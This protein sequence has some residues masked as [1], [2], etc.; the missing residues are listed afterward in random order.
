MTRN[1][2][3]QS[4]SPYLLQHKDNPVHWWP[5]VPDA[6][7]TAKREG[8]PILLSIGYAAC[9]WCHVMAHES[10]ESEDIAALMNEHFINIK[11]DREERPDIDHIYMSALHAL[12]EHGGW[13]LTMF[14]TPDAKPFWGGTYFPPT[15]RYG[16]PGFPR[17][18]RE[19]ARIFHDVPDK[20]A[21]NA[22]AILGHLEQVAQGRETAGARELPDLRLVADVVG[23]LASVVDPI[24]GGIQGAPKFP[25]FSFFWLLWTGAMRLGDATARQAVLT[26]LT[27]I[28]QGG[29]YDHLAGGFAR[30]SV[31]ERWLVPHFEKMLYD[32]ALLVS[33]MTEVW[34]ETKDPLLEVRVRETVGW[35]LEDMR[36]PG[37]AFASSYDADSEGE[38]GKYYVWQRAEIMEILGADD[39][40]LFCE[41]Y[42]V[43]AGGNFE[44][45]NILNRLMQPELGDAADEQHLAALRARLLARRRERVAPGFDDKVLADWNGYAIAALARAG[46]AFEEPTWVQAAEAAFAFIRRELGNVDGPLLGHSWREGRCTTSGVASDYA[47]MIEAAIALHE[48]T[49]A[50]EPLAH[51]RAWV[52][53]LE[54]RFKHEAGG[55]AQS[56]REAADLIVRMRSA[57]DDATPNANAIMVGA[58]VRLFSMT[59]EP[60]YLERARSVAEAFVGELWVNVSAHTGLLAAL[61]EL[62]QP[63]HIVVVG[64]GEGADRLLRAAVE[65]SFPGAVVQRAPDVQSLARG[66]AIGEAGRQSETSSAIALVCVGP[67]CAPA[68]T[69]PQALSE[70]LSRLR[71]G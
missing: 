28:C 66:T 30:Y 25:Q 55:Y 45:S 6:L 71:R 58:L 65:G 49:G 14:L 56:D 42:D 19:I 51:A 43:T 9:H 33:L 4:T 61:V 41:A 18:L 70:L 37:G 50:A 31:D 39:G 26:T 69:S 32:N 40:T 67:T 38:E 27:H 35:L 46:R 62:E 64:Q 17:V 44:G 29:I 60:T 63:A 57:R 11:V 36:L 68:T 15:D 34:R 59:G 12:G 16:R 20:V 7:E 53:V 10:F 5:W 22:T 13:P 1:R 21:S 8:K 47:A 24:H 52:D 3:D 48:V 54:D 23:K 2:L